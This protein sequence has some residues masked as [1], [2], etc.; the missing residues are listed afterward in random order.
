MSFAD[1]REAILA[2]TL[3]AVDIVEGSLQGISRR[4]EQYNC[5]TRITATRARKE[6]RHLDAL[7]ARGAPLPPLA[8]AT[9]AVKNL[10]DVEGEVTLA[11]S[12]LNAARA[13]AA[14]DATVVARLRDAGAILLGAVNMDPYAYGFTTENTFY[15]PTR[16]PHDTTRTSGGSSGGSGA[17]VAAGLV[18]FSLGSDTNGSIR[19]PSSFCGV[20]G[21]KPTYGRLP[22]TGAYPFVHS[23][24]H[25]GP[26]AHDACDLAALYEIMQGPDAGD[27][28]C[29]QRAPELVQRELVK[30]VAGLRVARLT[31]YFDRWATAPAQAA[32]RR[33]ASALG[34]RAEIELPEVERARAAAFLIT[35]AEG[36]ALHLPTLSRHYE[37]FEPLTRDRLLAGALQPG[38]WYLQAQRLRAWFRERIAQVFRDYDVLVAPATPFPATPLGEDWID[39]NGQRLPLRPSVGLLTQPL[40]FIGLPVAA[41]PM[42]EDGEL[43]MAVQLICAPWREDNC[44]RAA[45][46]LQSAAVARCDRVGP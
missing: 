20:Y 29:A 17:V 12:R 27:P 31:G 3:S 16:N 9:F 7:R 10:F 23:L 32:S 26:L 22:R 39:L 6:A 46:A 28:A 15:G 18:D 21:L 33:A 37:E 34:A 38:T 8:G 13:P 2:G 42:R 11:G 5:F 1:R 24:D 4:D 41:V 43:P 25:V 19:V 14:R 36:G 35:A 45:A 44:L 40:S 30:A